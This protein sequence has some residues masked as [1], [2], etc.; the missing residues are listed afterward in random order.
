MLYI[1]SVYNLQ[2]ELCGTE[3]CYPP[4][5]WLNW[6]NWSPCSSLCG[7]GI[8]YRYRKCHRE[9][10]EM[11]S[12]VGSAINFSECVGSGCE[13]IDGKSNKRLYDFDV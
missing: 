9:T 10:P 7:D 2:L 3:P 8:A 11:M 13:N 6:E 12:C 1:S 4:G 5:E